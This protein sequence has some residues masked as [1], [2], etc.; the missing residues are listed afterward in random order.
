MGCRLMLDNG[1][2]GGFR[3]GRE[4]AES[5]SVPVLDAHSSGTTV[6]LDIISEGPVL[7]CFLL[8]TGSLTWRVSVLHVW[9]TTRTAG[10]PLTAARGVTGL[11][12][13]TGLTG[14]FTALTVLII[15]SPGA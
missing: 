12:W 6:E 15:T 2:S 11:G 14:V 3:V 7:F 13:R 4:G 9:L 10:M 5:V 1:L 8:A